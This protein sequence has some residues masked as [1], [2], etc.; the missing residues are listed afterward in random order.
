MATVASIARRCPHSLEPA[1]PRLSPRQSLR[2]PSSMSQLRRVLPNGITIIAVENPTADIMTAR[3]F[4]QAGSRR[5]PPHQSGVSH[6]LAATLTKGTDRLSSMDIAERVESL[7]ASL[8]AETTSDYFLV[9][10]KTVSAD[11]ETVLELCAELVRSPAFPDAEVE[12]ERRLTLQAI[13]AQKEQPFSLAFSRLRE[14]MYGEHPYAISTLGTEASVAGLSRRDLQN[15][16]RTYFRPDRLVISVCGCWDGDRTLAA[17]TDAFGDWENP[18]LDVPSPDLP[19]IASRPHVTGLSQDTQQAI[20]ML[21]YLAPAVLSKGEGQIPPDYAALKLLSTYLGNG[22]SSRLFVE[23]REKRGLAYDVSAFYP[24]RIDT[25]QFVVYMGTAPQNTRIA[26]EGLRVEVERLKGL[27]LTE[28]ELQM[29]KNKLLGQYALGKQTNA[30][31]AQ[32]LGW[33]ETIGLGLDFDENFPEAIRQ[34]TAE[35]ARRVAN[36]YFSEPYICVVGPSAHIR[37]VLPSAVG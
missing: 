13:R 14:A 15:F 29:A 3:L 37:E 35:T 26:V 7:G 21:G 2:L 24:T 6:L 28:G 9:S 5:E 8:G 27:L 19:A 4:F 16:H 1:L 23:L 17:L 11:F 36:R 20:V 12:L 25:S 32:I 10:L 33:Y 30:Q 34:V 31:I 18:P 22:L